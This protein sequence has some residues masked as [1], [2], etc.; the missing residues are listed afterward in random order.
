MFVDTSMTKRVITIREETGVLEAKRLMNEHKIRHLPVVDDDSKLLGIVTD[1]DIRS[2][3]PSILM[4]NFDSA[5]EWDRLAGLPVR[6]IMTKKPVVIK[7]AYTI[8]DALLLIQEKK[9]GAFPVVNDDGKL[10]GMLSIRDLMRAFTNVLNIGEPGTLIGILVEQKVGQ[11]KKIVDAVT[12][13][14]ISFGSILVARHWDETK[15][16]VFI[17]LLTNNIIRIKKKLQDLGFSLLDPMAWYLDRLP[18]ND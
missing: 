17:Y 14:N 2:A 1:R 7:P 5:D 16:A 15:R 9:V 12:E 18:Q 6:E 11:L 10:E 3:L 13:E 8:H 4:E